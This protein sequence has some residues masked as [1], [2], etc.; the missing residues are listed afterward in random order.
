MIDKIVLEACVESFQEAMKAESLGA[1]RIELCAELNVGGT[2]PSY[3]LLQSVMNE[4]NIPVMVMIRPRGGNFVYD[5]MELKTMKQSID[6]CKSLGVMGVVFGLL[7]DQ[8]NIDIEKTRHL[9][10]YAAPLEVTFHK[11]IDETNDLTRAVMDL[12]QIKG[13]SRILT[14]GGKPT[15]LEGADQINEMIRTAGDFYKILAAGRIT[16]KNLNKMSEI[17]L[18]DEFH[19]RKIVGELN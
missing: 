14:S 3:A 4:L 15:A 18:T 10:E 7:D 12:K 11:A 9:T 19:G 8:N 17:L 13:I 5:T 1:N 6:I 2:T 16:N